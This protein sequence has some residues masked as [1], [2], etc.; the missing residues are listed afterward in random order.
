MADILS[1]FLTAK[2]KLQ[3]APPLPALDQANA[4]AAY[5]SVVKLKA[6]MDE[7]ARLR[8]LMNAETG[9]RQTHQDKLD[10]VQ[11]RRIEAL[12]LVRLGVDDSAQARADALD[13]EAAALRRELRDAQ[14]VADGIQAR[15]AT[16]EADKAL[17]ARLYQRDLGHYLD[18]VFTRLSD[19]Y[20]TL[21][22]EL[23]EVVLQMA[24]VQNVMLRYLAGNTNGFDRRILLPAVEPGNGR[25]LIPLLD[26]DSNAF[27]LGASVRSEDIIAE[28]KQAGFEW[29]F[30]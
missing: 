15:I 25:T 8:S 16:L 24:A 2:T 9:K 1:R 17:L 22:P 30:S 6:M 4:K 13:Q 12:T 5:E 21:A 14:S 3:P 10:D 29:K 27:F 18:Q 26:G 19:H 23:A 7:I 20:N 11:A 28:L